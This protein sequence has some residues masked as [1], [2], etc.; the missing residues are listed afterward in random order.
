MPEAY[1]ISVAAVLAGL[2]MLT[3]ALAPP[4]S[5]DDGRPLTVPI[6]QSS[7]P[8]APVVATQVLYRSSHALVIGIDEYT[9]GWPH[10]SNAVNDAEA[11][12]AALAR[13]G[14]DVTL[15][16]NLTAAEMRTIMREFFILKGE[17]PNARLFLWYAGH[18]HTDSNEGFLVP[19]DAP[20][21]TAGGAFR[22]KALHM[23]D[24]SGLVRL[25]QSKHVLAVFD[26]CFAGTVFETRSVGA[27]A[28]IT[29]ATAEPV[30]QFITS[31]D[32][33]Q[34]VSDDGTFRDLFLRAISGEERADAN[35]DGFVTG[36]ELGA[37]LA[38]RVT[39][40][41]EAAQTPRFGKLRDR[42]YDQGDFVFALPQAPGRL[43]NRP[44]PPAEPSPD[45]ALQTDLAF[46]ESIK[47]SNNPKMYQAYLD[48]FPD[49]TFAALAELKLTELGSAEMAARAKPPPEEPNLL[50]MTASMVANRSANVRA[51]PTTDSDK[52][53]LLRAGA[54]VQVT[55]RTP[56]PGDLW[57][58]VVLADG[59][60]GY[61]FGRLLT[62]RAAWEAAEAER[63][64]AADAETA[65]RAQKDAEK[66]LPKLSTAVPKTPP[67]TD[68]A[69][70]VPKTPPPSDAAPSDQ[71][72]AAQEV[73]YWNEIQNSSSVAAFEMY[74]QRYP[75]GLF[76]EDARRKM[77]EL[78]ALVP[79]VQTMTPSPPPTQ[80]DAG[81]SLDA[82]RLYINSNADGFRRQLSAYNA[83]YRVGG[84]GHGSASEFNVVRVSQ[85]RVLDRQ[86]DYVRVR[87]KFEVGVVSGYK[88]RDNDFHTL[89]VHL[90]P[91]AGGDRFEIVGHER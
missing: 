60:N 77:A 24:F 4:A 12:A 62:D 8:D 10:L 76:A 34:E 64:A 90:R 19:A 14:F 68:T 75:K 81:P 89:V 87:V 66:P 44:A 58:Q 82:A 7:A 70:T 45:T 86:R 37:H 11:I 42:Q 47:D 88:V 72:A 3:L 56:G 54:S 13:R 67:P 20:L 65:A 15:K 51:A 80:P 73:A 25:A 48:R 39:N 2:T 61:V 50:P 26:S 43:R 31:G 41:T 23:R 63:R 40:L 29:R 5:A 55:G 33:D 30:R 52:V 9:A 6:R 46:W 27:S 53:G 35:G 38:F 78:A 36:G 59:G 18:G 57:F 21:P 74:L 49:G 1:R 28:A 22:L 71:S 32:A 91:A 85:R 79:P 84:S 69:P 83:R 17:S 16:T